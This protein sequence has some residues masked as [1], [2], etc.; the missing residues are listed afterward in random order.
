MD[1]S[2]AEAYPVAGGPVL[3]AW[4]SAADIDSQLLLCLLLALL[5]VS[6]PER[7]AQQALTEADSWWQ[8]AC[9]C[10]SCPSKQHAWS[11]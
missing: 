4:G 3:V 6:R 9:D 8:S 1:I 7:E 10:V 2:L 5:L 11:Y